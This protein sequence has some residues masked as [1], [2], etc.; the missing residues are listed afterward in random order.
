MNN[1]NK[2]YI[3]FF[4]EKNKVNDLNQIVANYIDNKTSQNFDIS[5]GF[6]LNYIWHYQAFYSDTFDNIRKNSLKKAISLCSDE[7]LIKVYKQSLCLISIMQKENIKSFPEDMQIVKNKYMIIENYSSKFREDLNNQNDFFYKRYNDYY[8][9]ENINIDALFQLLT[10]LKE[11]NLLEHVQIYQDD[12]FKIFSTKYILKNHAL[13]FF[14]DLPIGGEKYDSLK[15]YLDGIEFYLDNY[16]TSHDDNLSYSRQLRNIKYFFNEFLSIWNILN[17]LKDEDLKI[18][19]KKYLDI[20]Q[21]FIEKNSGFLS[22]KSTSFFQDIIKIKKQ[23]NAFGSS[24]FKKEDQCLKINFEDVPSKLICISLS[25]VANYQRDQY[26]KAFEIKYIQSALEKMFKSIQNVLV[27]FNN[28]NMYVVFINLDNLNDRLFS[29]AI[30]KITNSILFEKL[31]PN[32]KFQDEY[33]KLIDKIIMEQDLL[34]LTIRKNSSPS[35][36]PITKF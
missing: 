28:N 31:N 22:K 17:S 15:L 34:E 2:E 21:N 5:I 13:N 20:C 3:V 9:D 18:Y 36:S 8:Y 33:E 6:I 25:E 27:T 19:T 29:N 16:D 23:K 35:K 11:R 14:L 26:D 10:I 12:F 32:L 30:Q 1:E 4:D 24:I 7:L